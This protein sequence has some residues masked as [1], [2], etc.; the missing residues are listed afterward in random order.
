[1]WGGG[2][3]Y[4]YIMTYKKTIYISHRG[5]PRYIMLHGK[6]PISL[7]GITTHTTSPILTPRTPQIA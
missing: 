6:P 3:I 5:L 7:G 4:I 1:M 2:N